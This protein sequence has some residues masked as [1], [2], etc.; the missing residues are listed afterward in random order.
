MFSEEDFFFVIHFFGEAFT[1]RPSP[2]PGRPSVSSA[3]SSPA[4]ADFMKPF[5]P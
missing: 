5:R 4:E 3:S 2:S 1:P